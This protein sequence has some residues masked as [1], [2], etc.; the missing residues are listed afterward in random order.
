[1]SRKK[2]RIGQM[3]LIYQ[4]DLNGTC[5]DNDIDVFLENFE[6]KE[7]EVQYI[8]SSMPVINEH[9]ADID[10]LLKDN[11]QGWTLERLAKVDRAILRIAVYEMLYRDD[12]PD[13]VSI[14]EAVELAKSYGSND[15]QKFINGILGSIYR[16]I[17]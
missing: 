4:I 14:N 13:E 5:D 17:H 3:Q 2:A 11:L 8:Q 1:M 9:L 15:S 16:S 12:I 6:F 7:D 10:A